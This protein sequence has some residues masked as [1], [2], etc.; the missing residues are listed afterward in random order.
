M[1]NKT[2]KLEPEK[3]YHI[4]N[5]AVGNEILFKSDTEYSMFFSKLSNLS[6]LFVI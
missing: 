6:F 2:E 1:I 3:Y 5:R 4:F